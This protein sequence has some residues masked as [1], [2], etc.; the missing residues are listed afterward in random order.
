MENIQVLMPGGNFQVKFAVDASYPSNCEEPYQIGNLIQEEPLYDRQYASCPIH[1]YAYRWNTEKWMRIMFECP[2]V[3]DEGIELDS[4][5]NEY[6]TGTIYNSYDA[7]AGEYPALITANTDSPITLYSKDSIIV[8]EKPIYGWARG[9]TSDDGIAGV[10]TDGNGNIY[11]GLNPTNRIVSYTKDPTER[12]QKDLDSVGNFEQIHDLSYNPNFPY[13]YSTGFYYYCGTSNFSGMSA[14][15]SSI[16]NGAT[17]GNYHC[18]T[19]PVGPYEIEGD[20]N[21]N[22]YI[23]GMHEGATWYSTVMWK[24]NSSLTDQW[25]NI[26]NNDQGGMIFNDIEISSSNTILGTGEFWGTVVDI[27]PTDGVQNFTPL[28][29]QDAFLSEWNTDGSKIRFFRWGGYQSDPAYVYANAMGCDDNANIF[30]GGT[31]SG[32][33]DFHPSSMHQDIHTSTGINGYDMYI[34]KFDQNGSY[35]AC[36]QI[37][38]TGTA[39]PSGFAFDM[40]GNVYVCGSF[41]YNTVDFNPGTGNANRTPVGTNSYDDMFIAKYTNNLDFVWVQT[42]GTTSYEYA[43]DIAYDRIYNYIYVV[44]GYGATMDFDPGEGVYEMTPADFPDPFLMKLCPSSGLWE[45]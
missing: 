27:D 7:P 35:L 2:E 15:R 8:T 42:W 16:S 31:Y 4:A 32:T 30:V 25:L 29:S 23:A 5:D 12:W 39:E 6:Y 26:W 1:L 19:V 40:Y 3:Y 38:G 24:V 22:A 28:G 41:R 11:F 44:G 21:G 13:L 18:L 43:N 36:V 34:T 37:N 45:Y 9:F 20:S 10:E 17:I 33:V 14:F